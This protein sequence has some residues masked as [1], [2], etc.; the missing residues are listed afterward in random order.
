ML[1]LITEPLNP[2]FVMAFAVVADGTITTTDDQLSED[3][4]A[5]GLRDAQ[6]KLAELLSSAPIGEVIYDLMRVVARL[7]LDL[8]PADPDRPLTDLVEWLAETIAIKSYQDP[9]SLELTRHLLYAVLNDGVFS[10]DAAAE[11]LG[12]EESPG[13]RCAI[14]LSR[15]AVGIS[16]LMVESDRALGRE[17]VG[18]DPIR[19][20]VAH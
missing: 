11:L 4:E 3:D 5:K 12:G 19:A 10:A 9:S 1:K 2:D 16:A 8:H 14:Y 15:I 13:T 7:L 20:I 17:D 18:G 6:S